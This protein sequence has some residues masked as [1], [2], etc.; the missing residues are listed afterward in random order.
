MHFTVNSRVPFSAFMVCFCHAACVM[1]VPRFPFMNSM[2]TGWSNRRVL[3]PI[4]ELF[5]VAQGRQ[6]VRS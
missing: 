3:N 4:S 1:G 6:T 2:F 5:R